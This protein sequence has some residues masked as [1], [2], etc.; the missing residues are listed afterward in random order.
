MSEQPEVVVQ[1]ES[2]RFSPHLRDIEVASHEPAFA[3]N[4]DIIMFDDDD[5]DETAEKTHDI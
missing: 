4:V 2:E 3:E 5:K 1:P